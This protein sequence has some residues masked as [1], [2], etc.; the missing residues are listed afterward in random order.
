MASLEILQFENEHLLF[1]KR[2]SRFLIVCLFFADVLFS[3][4][5]DPTGLLSCCKHIFSA[6]LP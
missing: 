1:V 5:T 2:K 6:L 4:P 3:I